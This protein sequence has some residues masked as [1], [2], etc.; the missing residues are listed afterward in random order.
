MYSGLI[1]SGFGTT[2]PQSGMHTRMALFFFFS[3]KRG[4]YLWD[5]RFPATFSCLSKRELMGLT[6]GLQRGHMKDR[7]PLV[8]ASHLCHENFMKD[9]LS[10][11]QKYSFFNTTQIWWLHNVSLLKQ[12]SRTCAGD[13]L[14]ANSAAIIRHCTAVNHRRDRVS[15]NVSKLSRTEDQ[16][17]TLLIIRLLF[18]GWGGQ[19]SSAVAVTVAVHVTIGFLRA[20]DGSLCLKGLPG[21]REAN[22]GGV[23][24]DTQTPSH[25]LTY[26]LWHT[27]DTREYKQPPRQVSLSTCGVWAK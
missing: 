19:N 1:H 22:W 23:C 11:S 18:F 4:K 9:A 13:P 24:L 3:E 5:V 14:F 20:M 27:L 8:K 6:K 17:L 10:H 25:T 26:S 2:I 16:L 21:D 15:E 12:H 7:R